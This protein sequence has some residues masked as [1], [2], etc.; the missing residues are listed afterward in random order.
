MQFLSKV[1]KARQALVAT[2]KPSSSCELK[3]GNIKN[4]KVAWRTYFKYLIS[5]LKHLAAKDK[6][7]STADIINIPF[8]TQ[9]ILFLDLV[10]NFLNR[11]V[12]DLA[13]GV[14]E[15]TYLM[16]KFEDNETFHMILAEFHSDLAFQ[17]TSLRQKA[18]EYKEQ[19]GS[20]LIS[21]RD[22]YLKYEKYLNEILTLTAETFINE[23]LFKNKMPLDDFDSEL[24]E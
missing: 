12:T 19:A 21:K 7:E 6:K 10:L 22:P 23:Y 17:L 15:F 13:T 20:L 8:N 9:Q 2:K 4:A 18:A 11:T 3:Y 24:L 16:H 1:E 14:L 5:N